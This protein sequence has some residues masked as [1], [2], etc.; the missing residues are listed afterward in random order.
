[1]AARDQ[2]PQLLWNTFIQDDFSSGV[3]RSR[4]CLRA[5]RN[6]V[7]HGLNLNARDMKI[8]Q[9]FFQRREQTY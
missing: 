5:L 2:Q 8:L 1:V 6:K 7:Q 3:R 4:R 9:D